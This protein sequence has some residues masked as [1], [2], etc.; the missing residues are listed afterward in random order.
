MREFPVAEGISDKFAEKQ[1]AV[2]TI[3]DDRNI[4]KIQKAVAKLDTSLPVLHDKGS[5]V[6]DAYRAFA[7]PTLVVLD[8]QHDIYSIWTGSIKERTDQLSEHIS[9]VLESD[10]DSQ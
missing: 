1:F 8:K 7:L 10:A 4:E 2:L 6:V 3:N 5:E 9:F